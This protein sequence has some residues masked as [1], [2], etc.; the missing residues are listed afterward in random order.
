[1]THKGGMMALARQGGRTHRRTWNCALLALFV[2][3]PYICKMNKTKQGFW[4]HR[5]KHQTRIY[6]PS[7]YTCRW[8]DREPWCCLGAGHAGAV[9]EG[10]QGRG[11]CA[12]AGD[13]ETLLLFSAGGVFKGHQLPRLHRARRQRWQDWGEESFSGHG[14][15]ACSACSLL[16]AAG[17]SVILQLIFSIKSIESVPDSVCPWRAFLPLLS[18]YVP[19][20]FTNIS[21]IPLIAY[22]FILLIIHCFRFMYL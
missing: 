11:D 3:L 13:N 9:G 21:T 10:W 5:L 22:L 15:V 16:L 17:G 8:R 18:I 12:V 7:S 19:V 4:G 20:T 1:M 14:A 2:P 6:E